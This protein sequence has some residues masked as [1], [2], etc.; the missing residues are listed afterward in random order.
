[1]EERR[2]DADIVSDTS[3]ESTWT[4]GEPELQLPSFHCGKLGLMWGFY[5]GS[6]IS[7]KY[8]QKTK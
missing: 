3:T 4:N 8:I 6:N 5:I 2:G 1:M 7:K